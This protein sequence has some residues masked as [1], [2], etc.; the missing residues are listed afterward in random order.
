VDCL[1]SVSIHK[2]VRKKELL[3]IVADGGMKGRLLTCLETASGTFCVLNKSPASKGRGE[4]Q[5]TKNMQKA[6]YFILLFSKSMPTVSMVKMHCE[7]SSLIEYLVD[8]LYSGSP[9]CSCQLQ[10]HKR[11]KGMST[12]AVFDGSSEPVILHTTHPPSHASMSYIGFRMIC[13]Y[14]P[15]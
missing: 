2:K 7:P 8:L 11:P 3:G 6:L 9:W 10:I 13:C 4:V 5:T 1:T 14:L 15:E 12:G